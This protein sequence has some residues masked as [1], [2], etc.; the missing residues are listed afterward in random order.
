TRSRQVGDGVVQ[1]GNGRFETVLNHTQ[2]ATGSVDCLQ[3]RINQPDGVSCVGETRNADSGSAAGDQRGDSSVNRADF[4]N[5]VGC[6]I[7]ANLDAQRTR[8]VKQLGAVEFCTAGDTVDFFQTCVDFVL[9]RLA[10]SGLVGIVSSLNG[11]LADTL[12]V[13]VD[14][15]QVA[16]SRLSQRDAVVG[17]AGSLGQAAD[18]SGHAVGNGLAGS[19]VFGAVDAQAGRQALDG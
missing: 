3:S 8:S 5:V 10:V 19:V 14:F 16:F 13:V 9:D 4:D 7:G 17:V 2:I 15:V 12:Q 11:Q 1:V 18:L 6:G